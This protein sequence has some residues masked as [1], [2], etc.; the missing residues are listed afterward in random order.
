[1]HKY[2]NVHICAMLTTKTY[3]CTGMYV[4]HTVP[5]LHMYTNAYT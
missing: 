1:M 3:L 4:R 5:W 2:T